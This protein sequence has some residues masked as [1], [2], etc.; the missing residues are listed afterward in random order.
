MSKY[1]L[2][3]M[4]L[5]CPVVYGQTISQQLQD[6]SDAKAAIKAAIE[7]KGVTVDSDL[8]LH[9]YDDSVRDIIIPVGAITVAGEAG[10]TI[11]A[12]D[13]VSIDYDNIIAKYSNPGTNT[14]F[15]DIVYLGYAN[16][17]GVA[18]D[19]INV[20]TIW[21]APDYNAFIFDEP[22][23]TITGYRGTATEI[24]VPSQI[25]GIDV[26]V[27]GTSAL[28]DKGL[29]S[30]TISSGITTINS[31]A[32]RGNDIATLSLPN[33]ITT[34]GTSAFDGNALTSVTLP[35]SLETLGGLA[36]ANNLI[37]SINIPNSVTS[38]GS[39]CWYRNKVTDA[40]GGITIGTG[41]TSLNTGAFSEAAFGV[42]GITSI[43]IPSNI[44]SIS[45]IV[46]WGAPLT[47]ITM[48]SATTSIYNTGT[49]T[50]HRTMGSYGADF[51]AAYGTGGAGTY[52]Y[53]GGTWTKE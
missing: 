46:F 25:N 5:L 37:T 9:R 7:S 50:D 18:S 53:S 13:I 16:E 27:I 28:E 12:G 17:A 21:Q 8:P 10:E 1:L 35:T 24:T 41:L 4:I 31:N 30:V 47:T 43:T 38:M 33:T 52:N 22:S 3:I 51:V 39:Y 40:G 48:A 34:I 14:D 36:F 32:F 15:A 20:T 42:S 2:L 6:I 45:D 44:G 29:T 19:I 23:Q 11:V 49:Y 26:L